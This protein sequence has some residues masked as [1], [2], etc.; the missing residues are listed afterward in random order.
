MR[1]ALTSF[2]VLSAA[3]L[4]SPYLAAAEPTNA[5]CPSTK[6]APELDANYHECSHGFQNGSCEKFVHT[7]KELLPRYDCQRSFDTEPV[8]AVWL[9]NSAAHEDYVRF[10]S[11]MKQLEARRLF[12]SPE[13]RATL[14]GALAE[15]YGPL[16]LKA[17]RA[18]SKAVPPNHSLQGTSRKLHEEEAQFTS[19]P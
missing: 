16:S 10:L 1:R 3:S 15:D 19:R 11:R 18:L 5:L 8:P 14:D 9:V 17:Q 7:F 2:M 13:F 6:L 12:A 4:L